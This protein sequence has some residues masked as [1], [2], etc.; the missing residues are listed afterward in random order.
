MKNILLK[1]CPV[2]ENFGEKKC[3]Y[4]GD[5]GKVSRLRC[6]ECGSIYFNEK[7]PYTPKYDLEYNMHFFRPGDIHKAGAMAKI[8]AEICDTYFKD[9]CILEIGTGNGLTVYNLTLLGYR[10][11]GMDLDVNLAAYLYQKF[12]IEMIVKD[13]LTYKS[14]IRWDFLYSSHVIEHCPEPHKFLEKAWEILKPGG[15]FLLECPNTDFC[16]PDSSTW[17]HFDTRDP[18]EHQTLIGTKA[19]NLLARKANFDIVLLDSLPQFESLRVLL[20]RPH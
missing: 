15:L 13:F 17:H 7:P 11:W 16:A 20:R 12:K 5:F 1:P 10:A 4:L 2:C 19:I 14:A 8:I 6:G 9:P 18:Y 3:E